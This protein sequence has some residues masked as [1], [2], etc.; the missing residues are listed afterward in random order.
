MK[1]I[2]ELLKKWTPVSLLL[3]VMIG[4]LFYFFVKEFDWFW[5]SCGQFFKLFSPIIVGIIL[6]YIFSP[7]AN[8][9]E[10]MICNKVRKPVMR[11][12][13]SVLITYIC[14]ITFLV[15]LYFTVIPSLI[16]TVSNIF[17]NID[18]YIASLS[19]NLNWFVAKYPSLNINIDDV[20][21]D[22]TLGAK[23]ISEFLKN[24]SGDILDFSLQLGNK[25]LNFVIGFVL[26][27]YFVCDR[28]R[29][30]KTFRRF[31]VA[32][33]P[34][35]RFRRTMELATRSNKIFLR[36]LGSNLFDALI[37]GVANAICMLIFGMPNI[38]LVTVIVATTNLIPTFG[39][40]I[41]LVMVVLF[42]ILIAPKFIL[43]F[44]ILFAVLQLIDGNIL[45]PRLFGDSVGL[46]PV[47]TLVAI[48]ACGR[49]F[50][51]W[52]MFIGVPL[53]AV[54]ASIIEDG[55]KRHLEIKKQKLKR[56]KIIETEETE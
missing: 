45:K 51:V 43:G 31:L 10:R 18:K 39:P 7:I 4:I 42:Y 47:W 12:T 1:R 17:M 25:V 2:K 15:I 37:I 28:R 6:G 49:L 53:V 16:S 35:A 8:F 24:N 21:R 14:I 38:V 40:W 48:V 9:F 13:I 56:E 36:Y 33:M 50:G 54:I 22:W 55:T 44:F 26:S 29:F 20:V 11:I 23:S 32:R 34:E 3:V 19:K 30:R 41:G 5:Y 27:I 52:G 46:R